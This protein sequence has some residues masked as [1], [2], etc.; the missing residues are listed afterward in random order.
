MSISSRFNRSGFAR[1]LNSPAGRVFR[2]VAGVLFLSLGAF[3]IASG[4][5][6]LGIISL[7]WGALPL[8]AGGFDVCYVS[9]A[10]GGPLSG[11]ACRADAATNTQPDQL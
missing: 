2:F 6:L 7:V 3:L 10:L 4:S 1:F 8:T 9:R 11:A 5:T